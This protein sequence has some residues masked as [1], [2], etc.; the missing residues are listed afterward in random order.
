MAEPGARRVQARASPRLDL[1]IVL[2]DLGKGRLVLSL[3][4]T[5]RQPAQQPST[6]AGSLLAVGTMSG[7]FTV[8][9]KVAEPREG[10]ASTMSQSATP[11]AARNYATRRRSTASPRSGTITTSRLRPRSTTAWWSIAARRAGRPAPKPW[12]PRA[13][14]H[15]INFDEPFGLSVVEALASGTSVIASNRGSMPEL[16]DHGVTGFLVDSVEAV[17]AIGRIGEINRAACRASARLSVD[18]MADHSWAC[19][20][21]CLA[22]DGLGLQ[23]SNAY[24]VT[25]GCSQR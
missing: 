19:T 1:R 7:P 10:I 21:R 24:R 2:E 6:P 16:I 22:E 4:G 5:S 23:A 12:A 11:T 25:L 9:S 18:R 3:P 13:L 17:E 15:L 8:D 20:A 14:L